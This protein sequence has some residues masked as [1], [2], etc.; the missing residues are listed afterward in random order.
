MSVS[1]AIHMISEASAEI[2]DEN[3]EEGGQVENDEVADAFCSEGQDIDGNEKPLEDLRLKTEEVLNS[4]KEL[5][6]RGQEFSDKI[7]KLEEITHEE[8]DV[9]TELE[10][11]A[12]ERALSVE[13]VK[14]NLDFTPGLRTIDR[15]AS[16]LVLL[17]LY[18]DTCHLIFSLS[19][20]RKK[21]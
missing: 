21:R 18:S 20:Q 15:K 17:F 10:L 11:L 4:I 13:A 16:S 2:A 5:E 7:E 8:R 19:L 3:E 14:S 9:R 6:A 12:K 1:S